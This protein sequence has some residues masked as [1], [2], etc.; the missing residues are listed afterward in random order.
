MKMSVLSSNHVVVKVSLFS[1][2]LYNCTVI[3]SMCCYNNL[4]LQSISTIFTDSKTE[5][6]FTIV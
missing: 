4:Q 3:V 1:K 6:K 2:E 5:K